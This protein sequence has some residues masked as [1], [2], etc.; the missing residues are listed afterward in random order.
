[1][2][3]FMFKK[4]VQLFKKS[5][6]SR[7]FL[8]N[9]HL[10]ILDGHGW[11]PRNKRVGIWIFLDMITLPSHTSHAKCILFQTFKTTFINERDGAMARSNYMKPNKIILARWVNKALD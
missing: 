7:I 2:T 3:F 1:M 11:Y 9:Y 8:T 5:I 10:L 4:F 6:P